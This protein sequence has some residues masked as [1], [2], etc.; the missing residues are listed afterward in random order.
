M[1]AKMRILRALGY[2]ILWMLPGVAI[3]GLAVVVDSL[4][5]LS[6]DTAQAGLTGIPLALPGLSLICS[7]A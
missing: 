6:S 3:L 2:G 1:E 5:I 4:G 7:T